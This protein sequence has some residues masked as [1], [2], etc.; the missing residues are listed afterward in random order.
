MIE[1]FKV[2]DSLRGLAIIAMIANHAGHYLTARPVSAGTYL[3]IY[4]SV[5]LAAPVFLF[6]AGFSQQ[7]SGR[8]FLSR[9]AGFIDYAKKCLWRGFVLLLSGFLINILFYPLDPWYRSRILALM[10]FSAVFG[11]LFVPLLSSVKVR[12][13]S[14]GISL[15]AIFCFPLA[16]PGIS[17]GLMGHGL[18]KDLLLSEFP[19]L[20]WVALYLLGQAAGE[21]YYAG[22]AAK[23]DLLA[24]AGGVIG[25]LLIGAWLVLSFVFQRYFLFNFAYDLDLNGYFTPSA[26]TWLWIMGWVLCGY[27]ALSRI[28]G[29]F[30]GAHLFWDDLGKAALAAYFLQFFLIRMVGEGWLKLEFSGVLPVL[31]ISAI[32]TLI[33]WMLI[34]SKAFARIMAYAPAKPRGRIF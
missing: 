6:V 23:R 25:A 3:M 19:I 8:D 15:A 28:H 31:A 27:F 13:I 1:R 4:I 26:I 16:A 2:L 18:A 12:I 7:L 21:L 24:A 22:N 9:G 10:A 30:P 34:K 29:D 32:I 11:A 33:I 5:T 17:A 20:P 14:I